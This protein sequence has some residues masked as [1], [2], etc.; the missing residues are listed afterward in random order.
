MEIL[1]TI[2]EISI[3]IVERKA[4]TKVVS[5]VQDHFIGFDNLTIPHILTIVH[6]IT[7]KRPMLV[8]VI[9]RGRLLGRL[10]KLDFTPGGGGAI[11]IFARTEGGT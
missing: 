7:M 3:A 1:L 2:I 11:G 9:T 4:K 5:P 6:V 10:T 8:N